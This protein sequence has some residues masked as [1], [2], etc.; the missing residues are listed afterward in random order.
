MANAQDLGLRNFRIDS[1]HRT[2]TESS[3]LA[4]AVFAL[5]DQVDMDSFDGLDDQGYGDR[6]D[7]GRPLKFAFFNYALLNFGWYFE[8]LL[9][10]PSPLVID[11][12]VGHIL[13]V[14][15]LHE[16]YTLVLLLSKLCMLL[17]NR[18]SIVYLLLN[19]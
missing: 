17:G 9:L 1:Q 11:E 12:W 3:C 2:D 6:L 19:G 5:G 8:V 4:R 16:L 10:I 7:V 15:V 13:G 14:L 18:F